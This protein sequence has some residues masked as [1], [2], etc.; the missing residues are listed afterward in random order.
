MRIAKFDTNVPKA[1]HKLW[2]ALHDLIILVLSDFAPTPQEMA[3]LWFSHPELS[4]ISSFDEE[5]PEQDSE[6]TSN[7]LQLKE[8]AKLSV[9]RMVQYH[10]AQWNCPY[11]ETF[12]HAYF[13]TTSARLLLLALV[14]VIKFGKVFDNYKR[15]QQEILYTQAKL[16]VPPLSLGTVTQDNMLKI[17]RVSQFCSSPTTASHDAWFAVQAECSRL[18]LCLRDISSVIS[19]GCHVNS[20]SFPH[21]EHMIAQAHQKTLHSHKILFEKMQDIL[22]LIDYHEVLFFKWID[23][24]YKLHVGEASE[25]PQSTQ[26][27]HPI[28][29]VRSDIISPE[30]NLEIEASRILEFLESSWESVEQQCPDENQQYLSKLRLVDKE[31]NQEMHSFED[32]LHR[33][34]SSPRPPSHTTPEPPH[35]YSSTTKPG[36]EPE[37]PPPPILTFTQ[38][39]PPPRSSSTAL[40]TAPVSQP[41]TIPVE[42][43]LHNISVYTQLNKTELSANRSQNFNAVSSILANL[44]GSGTINVHKLLAPQEP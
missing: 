7:T 34:D 16:P 39:A 9:V 41:P 20:P 12:S 6:S 5:T 43:I 35:T 18:N 15:K 29:V 8:Q 42:L 38:A 19:A 44:E 28:Q 24:V 22:N 2:R 37:P 11:S 14:W 32:T 13:N 23:S 17:K 4:Q 31:I 33:A 40:S 27:R 10:L 25:P 1:V 26:L 3:R 36:L 30:S 21:Y